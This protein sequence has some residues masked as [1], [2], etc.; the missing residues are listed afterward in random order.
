MLLLYILMKIYKFE[1]YKRGTKQAFRLEENKI[2]IV[3]Y[4]R[5]FSFCRDLNI[6][7]FLGKGF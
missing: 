7:G 3:L 6:G 4:V 1:N 2:F 5:N